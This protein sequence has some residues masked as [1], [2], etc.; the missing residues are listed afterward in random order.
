[1]KKEA[2]MQLEKTR[3]GE[4]REIN[5]LKDGTKK[6]QIEMGK[7]KR[8]KEFERKREN[9]KKLKTENTTWLVFVDQNFFIFRMNSG[10]GK[11]FTQ[12]KLACRRFVLILLI[13]N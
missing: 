10:I 12:S 7:Q 4:K 6:K 2:E 5:R 11:L 1:M 13:K 3:F 8:R 9:S